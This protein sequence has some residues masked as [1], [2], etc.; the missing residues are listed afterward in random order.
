MLLGLSFE[1]S[2]LR[3]SNKLG[4][5]LMGHLHVRHICAGCWVCCA[6]YI[7]KPLCSVDFDPAVVFNI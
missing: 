4:I 6:D 3:L 7:I 2:D 1:L 5:I